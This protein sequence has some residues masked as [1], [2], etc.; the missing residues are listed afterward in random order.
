MNIKPTFLIFPFLV[1]TVVIGTIYVVA[2]QSI[3]LGANDSQLQIA[4]DMVSLLQSGAKLSDIE[5]QIS[6]LR[7]V[8]MD[9]SL[10]PFVGVYDESGKALATS[11]YVDG[12]PVTPPSG[13]FSEAM[14]RGGELRITLEPKKGV[15]IAAVVRAFD[16]AAYGQGKGFVVS[17]KSLS[18]AENRIGKIGFLVLFGWIASLCVFACAAVWMT[19]ASKK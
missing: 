2:Q 12:A 15:R 13:V 19:R 1:V 11:G 4:G 9:L 6:A 16:Q 14:K 7:K 17:G 5:S 8:D 18:E 3:R 10:A